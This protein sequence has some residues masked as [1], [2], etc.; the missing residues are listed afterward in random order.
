[1]VAVIPRSPEHP[2]EVGLD[3][4]REW[5]E[6]NDPDNAEH[7]IVADLTWLLSR[8]SCA[9][10]TPACQGIVDG[11]ESD[12]CCTHGAYLSDKADRKRLAKGMSML[13]EDGKVRR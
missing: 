4:P 10:G 1:M 8:W 7:L 13:T 5:V 2:D 6:F 3:F 9:F 11:R 12:G